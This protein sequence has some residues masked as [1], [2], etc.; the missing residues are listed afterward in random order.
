M[1]TATFDHKVIFG[2][3]MVHFIGDFYPA[4]VNPV[5]PALVDKLSLSLAQVGLLMAIS[6]LLSF[7]TQPW[8]GYLADRQRTRFYILGGPLMT[9][10]FV[11]LIG[12]APDFWSLAGCLALGSIGAS[13]FHPTAAGMI[14]RYAGTRVG[15]CMGL[16]WLGGTMAFGLGPL[17][18]T[19][20]AEA[21]GLASLPLTTLLGLPAMILLFVL[22]PRPE[23]EGLRNLGFLGSIKDTLGPNWRPLTVIW[24]L[25]L[26]RTFVSQS[27][28][29][30]LPI[31]FAREGLSL[32]SVGGMISAYVSAAA[33]SGLLGGF[34]ADRIGYRPIFFVTYALATPCIYLTLYAPP[35]W[36]HISAALAGFMVLA[37][38]PLAVALAQ[39]LAPRAKSLV[40]SL[41][42]GLAFGVGGM[43]SPITGWL[44]DVFS[45][46]PAMSVVAIFPLL[47]V[48]LIFFVPESTRIKKA[49]SA[50]TPGPA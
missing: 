33:V 15:L 46:R 21:W 43:L 13:M 4:F 8:V 3:F 27:F 35:G 40:S 26:V 19:A 34:L 48:G 12:L 37:T 29:T 22:I 14:S 7:V 1:R 36:I 45:I 32:V 50:K 5:L 44:A 49:G 6:R 2:L 18:V 38:M 17:A 9:M 30:F 47:T 10:L 20:V 25:I 24:T 23:G 42:M 11:P 16:F 41:M 31:L 28:M 39:E